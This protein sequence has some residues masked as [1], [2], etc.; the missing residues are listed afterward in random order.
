MVAHVADPASIAPLLGAYDPDAFEGHPANGWYDLQYLPWIEEQKARAERR[1]G[2]RSDGDRPPVPAPVGPIDPD[3]TRPVR[4]RDLTVFADRLE[5]LRDLRAVRKRDGRTPPEEPSPG[6]PIDP[7]LVADE[8]RLALTHLGPIA[9]EGRAAARRLLAVTVATRA[10][11]E[12]FGRDGEHAGAARDAL[13]FSGTDVEPGYAADL[14]GRLHAR[15]AEEFTTMKQ[16]SQVVGSAISDELLP[17]TF[18]SQAV[19]PPCTGELILVPD[20]NGDEDPCLVMKAEFITDQLTFAQAKRYLVPDNWVYPDSLWCR[21]EREPAK[22]DQFP[23]LYHET[24]ATSCPPKTATWSVST[25]LNFWLSHPVSYEARAEYDLPNGVAKPF[26]DIEVDEGSLR[27]IDLGPSRGVHVK[28]TKRVRFAGSMDG[29]G[30]AMFMCASGYSSVLEDV[31]FR[32]ATAPASSLKPFPVKAPPGGPMPDSKTGQAKSQA[33]QT[34]ADPNATQEPKMAEDSL[35][36]ISKD[37]AD[38]LGQY[39]QDATKTVASSMAAIQGGTYKVENA[40]ADGIK[41]WSNYMNGVTKAFE[42]GSRTAKVYAKKPL[43]D[44]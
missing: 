32:I 5:R 26:A 28:T 8:I 25:D 37:T 24:V 2:G 35:E 43:D 11:P 3:R 13:T 7:A 40:W 22:D 19:V 41:L 12:F 9:A 44:Q 1:G 31:V 33:G 20:A 29:A 36:A 10:M 6:A 27:I 30:L 4:L 38:Y 34:K 23:W 42:L 39:L 16:W 14:A 17:E 15:L 21:M 18:R